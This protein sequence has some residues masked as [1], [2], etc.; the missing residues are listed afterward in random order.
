M[1]FSIKFLVQAALI[2]A[3][4]AAITLLLRPFGFG[5]VQ[6]RLAEA[7]TVLPAIIPAAIPGLFIGCFLA[8]WL[9]L[10]PM[11]DI[12]FGS[13]T[14][15]IAAFITYL[16]RKNKILL[17][18]PPVVLNAS[19]VGTYVYYLIDNTYALHIII[20][21]IGLSELIICYGLGLLLYTIVDRNTGLKK[22]LGVI[23]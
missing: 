2:A 21:S 16:L 8:N 22:I 14:T 12:V 20:L 7:L 17:P 9:G 18:L 5:P 15:L 23:E 19:I 10:A 1:K 11:V 4:Y 3:M 6:F 13:L